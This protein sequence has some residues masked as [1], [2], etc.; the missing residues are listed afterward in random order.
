MNLLVESAGNLAARAGRG[1]PAAAAIGRPKEQRRSLLATLARLPATA[2]RLMLELMA[3]PELTATRRSERWVT[4]RAI[5]WLALC[6][7]LTWVS[8]A[9]SQ[10]PES[11]AAAQG[12]AESIEATPTASPPA[13]TPADAAPAVDPGVDRPHADT[14]PRAL[15]DFRPTL[16]PHGTWVNDSTYGLVWVPSREVVGA[17]FAPYVTSGHWALSESGDEWVWVSDYPFGWVVFH[18]GRWVRTSEWGWAWVPGRRYAPAWVVWRVPAE[19]Y[20]YVGWGPAPPTFIWVHGFAWGLWD[21]P[22]IPYV[23]CAGAYVFH[24]RPYPYL[25][26]DRRLVRQLG[27]HTRRHPWRGYI[28]SAP[29]LAQARIL[30]KDVRTRRVASAAQIIGSDPPTVSSGRLSAARRVVP[31]RNLDR[32]R[33]RTAPERWDPAIGPPRRLQQQVRPAPAP[34]LPPGRGMRMAPPLRP[35]LS[36]GKTRR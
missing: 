3:A 11:P 20:G 4:H 13:P 18:Y 14:D 24:P 23:F 5:R 10:A 33:V 34:G 30:Q 36:S 1:T 2:S 35:N 29:T 9:L 7:T 31:P 17:Q 22:P 12:P 32:R 28:P 6:A 8:V 25:V 21:R 26:R 15:T 19:G 16:D 27:Q